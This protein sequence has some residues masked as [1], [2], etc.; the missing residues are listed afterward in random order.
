MMYYCID[1]II[2]NYKLYS[3]CLDNEPKY[4]AVLDFI[5]IAGVDPFLICT[6]AIFS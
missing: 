3:V 2:V 6:K 5:I 1:N 4:L